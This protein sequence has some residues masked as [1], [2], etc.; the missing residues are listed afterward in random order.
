M[1]APTD[2]RQTVTLSTVNRNEG[3][4]IF[5]RQ[6]FEAVKHA[7]NVLFISFPFDVTARMG[8]KRTSNR[9]K[10][11]AALNSD[12]EDDKSRDLPHFFIWSPEHLSESWIRVM[13]ELMFHKKLS[14][15]DARR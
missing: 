15:S 12:I 9:F 8:L 2:I 11:R 10:L 4:F 13:E 5:S 1:R 6:V 7:G 3:R 14:Y